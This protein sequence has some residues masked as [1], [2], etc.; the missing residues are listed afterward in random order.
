M[1]HSLGF[2][3]SRLKSIS[4][5][6]IYVQMA[7]FP[8]RS[9]KTKVIRSFFLVII[10]QVL[11]LFPQLNIWNNIMCLIDLLQIFGHVSDTVKD[12]PISS[13]AHCTDPLS[14][15]TGTSRKMWLQKCMCKPHAGSAR[16]VQ[17]VACCSLLSEHFIN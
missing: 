6:L 4:V 11:I 15:I 10:S 7:D 8:L 5:N 1:A 16:W 2:F 3:C 12:S 9:W 17:H 13:S 14:Q